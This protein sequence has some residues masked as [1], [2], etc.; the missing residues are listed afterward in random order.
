MA[1]RE[2]VTTTTHVLSSHR[3]QVISFTL[4]WT[5]LTLLIGAATFV[6]IYATTGVIMNASEGGSQPPGQ[7]NP[8]VPVVVAYN[9]TSG[10]TN[11][12][13]L[14]AIASNTPLSP[15]QNASRNSAQVG[16]VQS[17]PA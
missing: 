4:V 12:P 15:I 17:A 3:R 9:A 1:I 11:T 5:A 16:A 14:G 13:T 2:T 7:S 6:A 8:A 10:P